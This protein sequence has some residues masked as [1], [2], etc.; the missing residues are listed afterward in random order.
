MVEFYALNIEPQTRG[1]EVF[2]ENA[3]YNLP[4]YLYLRLD[5]GQKNGSK[6]LAQFF[7]HLKVRVGG[8]T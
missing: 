8:R 1:V 4:E 7:L 6:I 5:I 2:Q 3:F